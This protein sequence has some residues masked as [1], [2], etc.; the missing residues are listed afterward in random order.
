MLR[1]VVADSV[2]S[3]HIVQPRLTSS[4]VAHNHQYISIARVL[5][6]EGREIRAAHLEGCEL[7]LNL[8]TTQLELLDNVANFL[9]SL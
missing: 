3:I 8:R 2:V 1:R 9:K 6:D 7:R 5:T 4:A